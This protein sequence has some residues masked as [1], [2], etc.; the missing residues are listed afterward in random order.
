[1]FHIVERGLAECHTIET[2]KVRGASPYDTTA[3][4]S[5][6]QL[7]LQI[8]GA[9]EHLDKL[10]NSPVS[11]HSPEALARAYEDLFVLL[12]ELRR[13]E[14]ELRINNRELLSTHEIMEI[15]RRRYEELL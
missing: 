6:G 4:A 2:M 11:G 14:K 8:R 12:E 3:S 15:E 9:C 1:M 5:G 10:I 13:T 7:S